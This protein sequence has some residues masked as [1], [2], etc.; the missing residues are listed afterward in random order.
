MKFENKAQIGLGIFTVPD[1]ARVL[2][3]KYYKVERLLND[4]W[5]KRFANELGARYS[6]SDG[7]SRAVSFHTLVE[8]YM[9]YQL[10]EAGVSSQNIL[11]AHEVLSAKFNTPFPF[12]TS[13]IIKKVGAAGS[14]VVF[15]KSKEQILDLDFTGQ[16][17]LQFIVDF[18]KKLDFDQNELASRLWPL[19]KQ[20]AVV[21]DPHHQFGQPTV[22][23]TNILTIT[24]YNM[25]L[26]KDPIPFIAATYG[27]KEAAV[28]DAIDFCKLAA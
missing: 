22:A 21:V 1:I 5:D 28:K 15:K 26:S 4:Y 7:K 23:G 8:F 9:F 24:I 12:A 6:W 11:K 27:L 25:Y 20:K 14:K 18:I 3:L 16:L 2:N 19:G 17:N 13:G 10:K